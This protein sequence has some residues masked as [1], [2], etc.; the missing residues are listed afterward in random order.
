MASSPQVATCGASAA[1]TVRELNPKKKVFAQTPEQT[2]ELFGEP[3]CW[4][5]HMST[6]KTGF[7]A[8]LCLDAPGHR[9][10]YCYVDSV[11]YKPTRE[12]IRICDI[13]SGEVI[14]TVGEQQAE[15]FKAHVKGFSPCGKWLLC[16][17]S[18]NTADVKGNIFIVDT[19][20]GEIAGWSH[21]IGPFVLKQG[22][23]ARCLAMGGQA[24]YMHPCIFHS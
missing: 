5:D 3:V 2:E 16:Y 4:F 19:A 18:A 14:H 20:T 21:F 22:V 1:V 13:K 17:D 9:I 24:T 7:T 15:G 10:A 23:A 11:N 8:S 12:M 6:H